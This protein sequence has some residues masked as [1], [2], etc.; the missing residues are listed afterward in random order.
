M[1]LD[2]LNTELNALR[3]SAARLQ[4]DFVNQLRA[5]NENDQLS[6]EGK[7]A[8]LARIEPEY[9]A[10]LSE[11]DKREDAILER[12]RISLRQRITGTPDPTDVIAFRD[13]HDRAGKIESSE[14]A[15]TAM[16]R[17]IDVGDE[18]LAKA[19]LDQAIAKGWDTTVQKYTS[20]HPEMNTTITDLYALYRWTDNIQNEFE[21]ASA[22]RLPEGRIHPKYEGK[23][24]N[25]TPVW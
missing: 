8:E 21:R 9:S 4:N 6:M 1:A 22:Y 14:A 24:A 10:K 2:A 13:A 15:R 16:A 5:L 11:L 17:A 12:T 19:I 3:D 20:A 7:H 23:T 25:G 18:A